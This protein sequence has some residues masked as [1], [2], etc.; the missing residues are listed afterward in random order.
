MLPSGNEGKPT[1]R[2][3]SIETDTLDF[4]LTTTIAAPYLSILRLIAKTAKTAATMCACAAA[5]PRALTTL[6]A[7]WYGTS[8]YP[9]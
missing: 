9:W 5:L 2:E 4:T 8:L 1:V 6:R 3:A 7:G